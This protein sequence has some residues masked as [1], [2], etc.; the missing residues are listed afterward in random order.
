MLCFDTGWQTLTIVDSCYPFS[1]GI[2]GA[3]LHLLLWRASSGRDNYC[4][5]SPN[6]LSKCVLLDMIYP[7]AAVYNWSHLT[8]PRYGIQHSSFERW[9]MEH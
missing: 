9:L 1:Q 3:P 5:V 8:T 4:G 2:S 7:F 6:L